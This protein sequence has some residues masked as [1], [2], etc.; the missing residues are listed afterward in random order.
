MN[1][2]KITSR[3]VLTLFGLAAL[4][5]AAPLLSD[6]P[7]PPSL[8]TPGDGATGVAI[9]AN[10]DVTVSDPEGD[11]L[12]VRFYGRVAP[13][14]EIGDF[15]II[16]IPDT[17]SYVDDIANLVHFGN[18]TQ[19]IV[20]NRVSH[21]IVFVAGLGD[22]VEHANNDLEWLRAEAAYGKLEDPIATMLPD[23]IPY[24]LGVGNH[25][26]SPEAGGSSALRNKFNQYFGQARFSGRG[27]YGGHYGINNDNSYQLVTASGMDFI[28]IHLEYDDSPEQEALEWA[29][30]LLTTYADHRAVIISHYLIDNSGNFGTSGQEI[31][32]ALSHHQN[33]FLM[34]AGHLGPEGRR[35]DTALNDNVVNTLMSN[36][37][38]EANGGN[39]YLRIMTFSP[40]NGTIEVQTYSP[41]LDQ[42]DVSSPSQFTLSYD[43]D[44]GPQFALIGQES[45]V[46]SGNPAN[47][48]WAGLEGLTDFEWYV[49]VDDGNSALTV[50]PIW[51]FTTENPA[52]SIVP[53]KTT[54]SIAPPDPS[55]SASASFVFSGS[56]NLTDPASL[57]FECQ[58]DRGGFTACTSPRSYSALSQGDHTFEVKATDGDGN[59]EPN[60]AS[61]AWSIDYSPQLRVR[62]KT[63]LDDA[64]ERESSGDVDLDS[65]DLELV[66]DNADPGSIDQI[67]GLRFRNVTLPTYWVIDS[68][69]IEFEA[70]ETGQWRHRSNASW[71]GDGQPGG[72]FRR[73]FQHFFEALDKRLCRLES[74]TME[75]HQ[76]KT[77]E[78]RSDG[79]LAGTGRPPGLDAGQPDGVHY[80]G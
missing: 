3:L 24:G 75:Q 7:N 62:I 64:E 63:W 2:A 57:G 74:G 10:L 73:K 32:N 66:H 68:A 51:T 60:P 15:T 28:F 4:S 56:D 36:Y 13:P 55:S 53:P 20:D 1:R 61:H 39:G 16:A 52:P 29:D 19:W 48:M 49:T 58:L 26:Q 80:S 11:A 45:G 40:T 22:I 65:S 34:L 78:Q 54:I 31:Y 14:P 35:Q 71:R 46:I 18:Q 12:T 44:A 59:T 37:Q 5:G 27:Y 17:Q 23:G 72:V 79:N 70:D 77:P 50:G 47:Q 41:S 9:T 30:A 33:L 25:D 8:V 67:V 6:P 38:D 21:S 42:F 43:M 69:Y 76:R